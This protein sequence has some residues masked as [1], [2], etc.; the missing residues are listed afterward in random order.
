MYTSRLSGN[1][2][3][4]RVNA[5]KGHPTQLTFDSS[6][7]F[8]PSVAPEGGTIFFTS[9]RD[10]HWAIWRINPDGGSAKRVTPLG[11]AA[12]MVFPSRDGKWLFY[13]IMGPAH[14]VR[15]PADGGQVQSYERLYCCTVGGSSDGKLVAAMQEDQQKWR[16]E[17]FPVTG[18]QPVRI[19]PWLPNLSYLPPRLSRDG[20]RILYADVQHGTANLWSTDFAGTTPKQVTHFSDLQ[21][22]SSFAVAADGRIAMSRGTSISDAVLIRVSFTRQANLR[23][24]G[25]DGAA[26]APQ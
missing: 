25:S 11:Q 4:W 9:D 19:S 20:E 14:V 12:N 21:R 13:S 8:L 23:T 1:W 17:M 3:L 7:S 16:L 5:V 10:G 18:G 2:N 15:M 22:I 26:S 6:N 24:S